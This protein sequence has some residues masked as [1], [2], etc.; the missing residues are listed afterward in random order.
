[1]PFVRNKEDAEF[2]VA[3]FAEHCKEFDK[4]PVFTMKHHYRGRYDVRVD[5]ATV[6]RDS[7][8]LS[9]AM[10]WLVAGMYAERDRAE[11]ERTKGAG[12][13]NLTPRN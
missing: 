2:V 11:R 5:E 9:M 10:T 1:M 13:W 6:W 4:P 8:W 12:G 7:Q 3:Y